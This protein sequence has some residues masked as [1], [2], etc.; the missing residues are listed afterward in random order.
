MDCVGDVV[1]LGRGD[2]RGG[3]HGCG[4]WLWPV[5]L[6]SGGGGGRR[7][8]GLAGLSAGVWVAGK[9]KNCDCDSGT[10]G[11]NSR[12][13]G[14]CRDGL[15]T[16]IQ[17]RK[18]VIDLWLQWQRASRVCS[19]LQESEGKSGKSQMSETGMEHG[20][21]QPR[22]ASIA[23]PWWGAGCRRGWMDRVWT[24][25]GQGLDR[26]P[27]LAFPRARRGFV[28][29][30]RGTAVPTSDGAKGRGWVGRDW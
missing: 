11:M 30:I 14:W 8:G 2:W 7:E 19:G 12:R 6:L 4:W 25:C 26:V 16:R 24:G 3:R 9:I 5:V 17:A 29:Y 21:S 1:E 13:G 18:M 22:T 27:P 28:S 15:I 20:S 23:R 10:S